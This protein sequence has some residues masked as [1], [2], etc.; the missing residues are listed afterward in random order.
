ME[1]QTTTQFNKEL[2]TLNLTKELFLEVFAMNQ[3]KGFHPLGENE[4][5]KK[6]RLLAMAVGEVGE[7]IEA[8]RKDKY[9][10]WKKFEHQD[11]DIAFFINFDQNIKDSLEDELA[12]VVIRLYDYAGCFNLHFKSIMREYEQEM[13]ALNELSIRDDVA[14]LFCVQRAITD[15]YYGAIVGDVLGEAIAKVHAFAIHRKINLQKHIDMKLK[16]N[17]MRPFLHDKKF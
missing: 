2:R 17:Q 11:K 10:Q 12:D 13:E 4:V 1:N 16:Y 3:N 7:A 5:F 9:A 8:L 6:Q 15:I 14:F